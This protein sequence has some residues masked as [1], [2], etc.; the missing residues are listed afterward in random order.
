MAQALYSASAA[1]ITALATTLMMLRIPPKTPPTTAD[2]ATKISPTCR[3]LVAKAPTTVTAAP[4]TPAT[5]SKTCQ[6]PVRTAPITLP[7][8]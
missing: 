7:T 8:K 1:P 3:M 2:S 6:M 4:N 5:T